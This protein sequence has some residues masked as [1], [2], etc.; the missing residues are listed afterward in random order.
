MYLEIHAGDCELS[1]SVRA[2]GNTDLVGFKTRVARDLRELLP[3]Y[4]TVL[5]VQVCPGSSSW[6][7]AMGSTYVPMP[8]S[9]KR[10]TSEAR[11]HTD[12]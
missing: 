12:S 5:D 8:R 11:I 2:G 9:G 1:V 3:E 10:D 4:S 7:V 6:S